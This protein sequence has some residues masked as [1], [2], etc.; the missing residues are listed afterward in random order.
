MLNE[1]SHNGDKDDED[2]DMVGNSSDEECVVKKTVGGLTYRWHVQSDVEEEEEDS[3]GQGYGYEESFVDWTGLY[4]QG[5]Y[6]PQKELY[7]VEFQV[8]VEEI[9]DP[10]RDSWCMYTLFLHTEDLSTLVALLKTRAA[11]TTNTFR[12]LPPDHGV[13]RFDGSATDFLATLPDIAPRDMEPFETYLCKCF[14]LSR[15]TTKEAI[16]NKKPLDRRTNATLVARCPTSHIV[17]AVW[18]LSHPDAVA[19]ELA[20]VFKVVSQQTPHPEKL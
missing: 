6:F 16:H 4:T 2:G 10:L 9:W 11:D 14:P 3:N 5:T 12:W 15:R 8:G 19:A 17:W 13:G 1:N 7:A 18:F 20:K